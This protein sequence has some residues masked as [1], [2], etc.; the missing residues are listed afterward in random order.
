MIYLRKTIGEQ[1]K[2]IQK[3]IMSIER[4]RFNPAS[5][6]LMIIC[7]VVAGFVWYYVKN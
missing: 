6:K 5:Y 7:T 1:R 4:N 3:I 2:E